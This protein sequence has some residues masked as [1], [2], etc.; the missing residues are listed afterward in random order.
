[1]K[2]DIQ[3]IEEASAVIDRD[4][5]AILTR[6]GVLTRAG[7]KAKTNINASND[8]IV[9]TDKT[10]I[11]VSSDEEFEASTTDEEVMEEAMNMSR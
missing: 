3:A 5:Q 4:V 8:L 1:M 7:A 6:A 10:A 11:D 9:N 2:A